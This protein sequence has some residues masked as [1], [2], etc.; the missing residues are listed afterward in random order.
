MTDPYRVLGL[1]RG[2]SDEDIKKAYR[3]LSRK[4]HPDAN[5]NNPNKAEAEERF[6]EVQAAYNQIMDE[7]QHGYSGS[8]Y[9]YGGSSYSY[10][11]AGGNF[12]NGGYAYKNATSN[13]MAAAANYINA[14]HYN[15]AMNV[16]NSIP[17]EQRNGQW[18]FFAAVAANGMGNLSLAKEYIS[19]A[20]ALEPG[21]FQY[22]SFQQTLDF[23]SGWYTSYDSRR[24]TYRSPYS[25]LGRWCLNMLILN[26][27]CNLCCCGG[28]RF[29]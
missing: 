23:G 8:T 13:E 28:P 25:G 10:G 15:E 19:R 1:T 5:V 3:N 29:Y 20:V 14:G 6:K 7:K 11:G 16:L 27:L 12:Y 24:S 21:N 26:L 18:Y 4:Y 17:D 2:A 22:R 9:G